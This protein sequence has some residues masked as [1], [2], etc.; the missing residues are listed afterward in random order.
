MAI[1][2]YPLNDWI[3]HDTTG[4]YESDCLCEPRIE[5]IDELTSLPNSEPI[6]IH[7]AIDGRPQ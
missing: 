1:H 7:N 4:E 5:F 3:D 2:V 6:I